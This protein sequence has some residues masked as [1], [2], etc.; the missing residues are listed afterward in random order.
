VINKVD[1]PVDADR[2]E[3]QMRSLF[4]FK[5][6]EILRISAKSGLNVPT[7]LDAIVERIPA[8]KVH[9]TGPLLAH[10]FDSW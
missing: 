7:I 4:D 8:P 2:V 6:D 3:R 5:S 9:Q 10:V 1:M